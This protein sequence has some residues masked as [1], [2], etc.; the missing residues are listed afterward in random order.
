MKLHTVVKQS[1]KLW[2]SQWFDCALLRIPVELDSENYLE[3]QKLHFLVAAALIYNIHCGL[4]NELVLV[5]FCKSI[6]TLVVIWLKLNLLWIKKSYCKVFVCLSFQLVMFWV[7]VLLHCFLL[8]FI[9]LA[10]TMLWAPLFLSS[11]KFEILL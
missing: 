6:S 3:E 2:I 11:V 10:F 5:G 4:S 8:C 1:Y 7:I 9:T